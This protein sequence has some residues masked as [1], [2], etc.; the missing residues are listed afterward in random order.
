MNV[1]GGGLAGAIETIRPWVSTG[2]I[3]GLL[4]LAVKLYLDNRGLRLQAEKR[5]QEYTLE[6]SADGR[7]NLQFII[8]NLRA[9]IGRA[10]ERANKADTRAGAAELAHA[11]CE[12]ELDSVR[13]VGR[14][15]RDK[16]EGLARQFVNFADSVAMGIP[17]GNWSPE[18]TNMMQQ[19]AGLGR[20]ARDVDKAP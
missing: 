8:D 19:L 20:I 7:T 2:G 17:P 16:L 3:L 15:T 12:K 5:A 4:G 13:D 11:A 18:I 6:V 9:D 10:D 1:S 14:A